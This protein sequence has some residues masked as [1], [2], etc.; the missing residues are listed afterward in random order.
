MRSH[1]YNQLPAEEKAAIENI[2]YFQGLK[3]DII[4][5]RLDIK[6]PGSQDDD[7]FKAE[8]LYKEYDGKAQPVAYEHQINTACTIFEGMVGKNKRNHHLTAPFQNGKTGVTLVLSEICLYWSMKN[9]KHAKVL[10]V[11]LNGQVE[12]HEQMASRIKQ[13]SF[14]SCCDDWNNKVEVF[15]CNGKKEHLE[16]LSKIV[17]DTSR[18]DHLL[19][20]PDE[21]QWGTA[22][23]S[24]FDK[25]ILSHFPSHSGANM[26]A[27]GATPFEIMHSSTALELFHESK[28]EVCH[29][30][31]GPGSINGHA[32]P[33]LNNYVEN[34]VFI[35]EL[36][37]QDYK[38]YGKNSTKTLADL[39]NYLLFEQKLDFS[40]TV[41]RLHSISHAD[42]AAKLLSDRKIKVVKHYAESNLKEPLRRKW[43]KGSCLLIVDTM[44][45]SQTLPLDID[46]FIDTN[47][48]GYNDNNSKVTVTAVGQGGYGRMCGFG[49]ANSRLITAPGTKQYVDRYKNGPFNGL[50]NDEK[51]LHLHS[52]VKTTKRN[53]SPTKLKFMVCE[54]VL[55]TK[56]PID[57]VLAD[58]HRNKIEKFPKILIEGIQNLC[59]K[60]LQKN[61]GIRSKYSCESKG[62]TEILKYIE[63]TNFFNFKASSVGFWNVKPSYEKTQWQRNKEDGHIK[64]LHN[65]RKIWGFL[66]LEPKELSTE[67][68][69]KESVYAVGNV[70]SRF[71]NWQ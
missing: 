49:R 44:K 40:N 15:R 24:N 12:I 63:E 27:V 28:M 67:V 10:H 18:Y 7:W 46:T 42:Q 2:A 23:N 55:N 50:L 65:E 4:E 9:R 1:W 58:C 53:L 36:I 26:L 16:Q 61:G 48:F 54:D 52:R 8:A 66:I 64:F 57:E 3:R 70:E 37:P 11:P 33:R 69:S 14:M 35:D 41:V 47:T 60:Y 38:Y 45:C 21:S 32:W 59:D 39:L 68:T 71:N 5:N 30:Y 17:Q 62:R 56:F 20:V 6:F 25:M 34:D 43:A 31:R 13:Y 19:I 22:V 29:G 51:P